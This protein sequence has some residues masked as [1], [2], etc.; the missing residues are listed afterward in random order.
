MAQLD[1]EPTADRLRLSVMWR[2]LKTL[3]RPHHS[4]SGRLMFVVLLTT[5]LALLVAGGALLVTDLRDS[6]RAWADDV[7]TESG[8][9]ALSVAPALSFDDRA[10]A[11]RSLSA[12]QAKPS[13]VIAALYTPQGNLY[14]YTPVDNLPPN[15]Q[16]R[17]RRGKVTAL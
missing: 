13:I 4:I 16:E 9:L 17:F 12:L 6:R 15:E 3:R 2:A 8:I 10:A 1:D 5:T 7:S 14:K 11:S